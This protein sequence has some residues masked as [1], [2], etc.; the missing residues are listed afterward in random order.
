MAELAN[1]VAYVTEDFWVNADEKIVFASGQKYEVNKV[2][3]MQNSYS[4]AGYFLIHADKQ[5][6][7]YYSPNKTLKYYLTGGTWFIRG[8]NY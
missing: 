8:G 2:V 3:Q 6:R 5:I 1:L 4:G 7:I